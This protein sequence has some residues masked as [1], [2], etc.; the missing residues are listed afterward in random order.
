MSERGAAGV[1]GAWRR[2][3]P[4]AIGFLFIRVVVD[5]A[6]NNMPVLLGAGA[7]IALIERIGLREVVLAGLVIGLLVLLGCLVFHRRFR[8]RLDGDVLLVRRGLLEHREL[9]VR[10]DSVQQITIE[11]PLY[12]RLFGL[13]RFSAATPGGAATE[14]ELPGIRADVAADL[15]RALDRSGAVPDADADVIPRTVLY[16]ARSSALMLHGVASNY[17]WLLVAALTPFVQQV[18]GILTWLA[19]D[20]SVA[21]ALALLARWPWLAAAGVLL[22]LV[23]ILVLASVAAAWFR[24]HG[25]VLTR[26]GERFVQRCGLVN[27][28]EQVLSRARLQAVEQVQTLV[29]RMLGR[30]HLVCRQV[31]ATAPGAELAGRTFL[32][33]GL[34][35]DDSEALMRALWPDLDGGSPLMRVH[36][37]YRAAFALRCLMLIALVLVVVAAGSGN[38]YW[39]AAIAAGPPLSWPLAWLR[40][41][42]LGWARTGACMRVRRGLL[43]YRT[44]TFPLERVQ[45]VRLNQTWFQAR[46]GLVSVTLVLASGP[47]TIPWIEVARADRLVNEALYRAA[48]TAF[49]SPAAGGL[50]AA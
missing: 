21:E 27:R 10:A 30:S 20:T 48:T 6:R 38:P 25:F 2:L 33:P 43:G 26:E 17:A 42:A 11:Q 23:G 50:P 40:W 24:F 22:G 3:S 44:V 39:I 32:V 34:N 19:A 16:R 18:E 47:V 29:G 36:P 46:R 49:D 35:R 13:V 14:V 4:L 41:R 28:R 8:F 31:G 45:Q 15:R 37:R 1:R 7:G 12:L 5:F 9:K